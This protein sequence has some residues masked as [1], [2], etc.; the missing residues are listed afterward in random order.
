MLPVPEAAIH[1]ALERAAVRLGDREAI[2]A[3][4]RQWSFRQLDGLSN[5]FAR[6][7][8]GYGVRPGQRVCL[9][10]SNR[11]E[12]V[13]AVYAI[14]KLGAAAVLL[15][16]AWKA[17]EV[18]HAVGVGDD[19]AETHALADEI[20]ANVGARGAGAPDRVGANGLQVRRHFARQ[21]LDEARA[22]ERDV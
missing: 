5:S 15:S 4:D 1:R 13:V 9:M 16:P 22:H 21:Q 7:L 20:G 10:T 12:F 17:F 19:P 8:A 6:H 14:S 2:L 18:D 11:P 3:G